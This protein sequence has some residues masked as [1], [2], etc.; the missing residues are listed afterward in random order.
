[1]TK[2]NPSDP[3]RIIEL[4]IRNVKR[5]RAVHIT[6]TG[7]LVQITGRNGQGKTTV[8]DSIMYVL[9]GERVIPEEPLRRGALRGE[10]VLDLGDFTAT[11]TFTEGKSSLKVTRKDG[12]P[13]PSP[14]AWLSSLMGDIAFDPLDFSRKDPKS[15]AAVLRRAL[16]LEAKFAEID[17]KIESVSADRRTIN[18]QAKTAEARLAAMPTVQAPDVEEDATAI[19][20][21]YQAALEA[22]GENRK[23][24]EWLTSARKTLSD[25]DGKIE[26]LRAQL[27]DAEV[28]RANVASVIAE[29]APAIEALKDP[30]LEALAARVKTMNETNRKVA[31]KRERGR[32]A[33][34]IADLRDKSDA[35]DKAIE[36]LRASKAELVKRSAMPVEGLAFTD[37]GVTLNGIELAECSGAERLRASVAVGLAQNPKLR[38]MLIRDGSLL[39]SS[40]LTELERIATERDAQV[41]IERVD[42]TGEVGVV[43]E[44]GAVLGADEPG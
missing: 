8:L 41:W 24:R 12:Q 27:A 14:Q 22:T 1:M 13:M 15:Q 16:G 44:D 3:S 10:V 11:R 34:E 21:E 42:E 4:R 39:D 29:K 9:G 31:A 37:D 18:S 7:P 2:T 28:K 30:D 32:L 36:N 33:G 23:S 17:A 5:V 43:I 26:S 35:M 40:S 20:M 19:G 25:W 6:P 38:V